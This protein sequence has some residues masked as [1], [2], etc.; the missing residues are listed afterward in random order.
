MVPMP[1]EVLLPRLADS[2]EPGDHIGRAAWD[3]FRCLCRDVGAKV[4]DTKSS[5]CP[6]LSCAWEVG[7]RWPDRYCEIVYDWGDY[8]TYDGAYHEHRYWVKSQSTVALD[9]HPSIGTRFIGIGPMSYFDWSDYR[10]RSKQAY[11]P[12]ETVLCKEF[13]PPDAA[14]AEMRR[15]RLDVRTRLQRKLGARADTDLHSDLKE[16]WQVALG[17]LVSVHSRGTWAHRLGRCQWQLMALGVPTLSADIWTSCCGARPEAWRH[18]VPI[19][20]DYSDLE[21]RVD[22]CYWHPLELAKIGQ[23]AKQFF[24]GHGTPRAIWQFVYRKLRELGQ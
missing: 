6:A 7:V 17:C 21:S 8:V 23:R 12:G 14:L 20:D 1:V 5:R 2:V 22:W 15:C 11:A 4:T 9:E 13:L 18:Y 19:L 3:W 16:Y 24:E 10:E